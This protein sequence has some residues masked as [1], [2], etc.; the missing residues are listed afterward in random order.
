MFSAITVLR[1]QWHAMGTKQQSQHCNHMESFWTENI[2]DG[3]SRSSQTDNEDQWKGLAMGKNSV[4]MFSGWYGWRD[5]RRSFGFAVSKTQGE[6][7][8]IWPQ[9]P[10]SKLDHWALLHMI[11]LSRKVPQGRS[12]MQCLK[13]CAKLYPWPIIW[14]FLAKWAEICPQTTGHYRV[15]WWD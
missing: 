5:K 3:G 11:C 2:L 6:L 4:L 10:E 9:S 8:E 7:A 14:E 12:G 1:I 13:E 15:L